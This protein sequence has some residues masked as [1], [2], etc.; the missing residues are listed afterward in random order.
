M[1][2]LLLV[3]LL[4]AGCGQSGGLTGQQGAVGETGPAGTPDG[5]C[6]V[7]SL[8][9]SDIAPN[10][11]ALI[12]CPDLTQV[13][14]LNGTNGIDGNNGTN[15]IDGNNGTNGTNGSDAQSVSVVQFC[16][17]TAHYPSSFPEVGFY[18]QG[19][20]YGV[21]SA[22]GGFMSLLTPGTYSS[23]GINSSCTFTVNAD[24]SVSR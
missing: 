17:G 20:L 12:S 22:N 4:A 5:N 3:C 1:K 23:N 18:I 10:G 14:I 13:V 2:K 7:L 24:Y 9:A 11:G 21:Y 15:G 19:K 6:S 8:A 16:N